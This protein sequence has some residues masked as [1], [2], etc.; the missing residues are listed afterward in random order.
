[1]EQPFIFKVL[2]FQSVNVMRLKMR[3]LGITDVPEKVVKLRKQAAVQAAIIHC[4]TC[5]DYER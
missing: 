5:S 2:I 1:M 4:D 3:S